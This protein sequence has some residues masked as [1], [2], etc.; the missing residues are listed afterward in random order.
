MEL[1]SE[2]KEVGEPITDD[3]ASLH[4]FSYKLEYLLQVGA[5]HMLAWSIAP[6]PSWDVV[7][8]RTELSPARA[9]PPVCPL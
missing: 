3:S 4:K 6:C 9:S 8:G 2:F 7:S 5:P 1:S